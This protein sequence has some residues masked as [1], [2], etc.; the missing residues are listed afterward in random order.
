MAM[1]QT[2]S[3]TGYSLGRWDLSELLSS[4]SDEIIATC[5]QSLGSDV[6]LLEQAR[7]KLS[8]D[9]E[10][11]ELRK[12]VELYESIAEKI[13]VLSA[14]GSL[15]FA[16]DTQD[17]AAL[18]YS[19]R[20]DQVLT[21][22][23]NRLLFFT[24]WWKDLDDEVAKKLL[25]ADDDSKA[26][27]YRHF[28]TD[29]RRTKEYTL[30][31]ASERLINIKD[32][33]GIQAVLTLYSMLTNRLE[34]ELEIDGEAKTLSRSEMSAL[35][36]S[37]DSE[38]R[39]SAYQE[40]HRVYEADAKILGQIYVNRVS[41]WATE[42]R[43]LRGFSSAIGVRNV[44][45]DLPDAAVETLLDV[46][47]ESA[48]IFQR[49]FRLK[50]KWLGVE[51]LR[52]YDL[53]APLA[54]SDRRIPW[55]E[56]V[57]TVLDTFSG[58]DP[59]V[60]DLAR[61][62]FADNHIDS[63]LRKGKKGGAFCATVLPSQTPWVL[64]NYTGKVRDVATLAHELG[65]AVHSLLAEDH[66]ILTQHA[67]L[68]LAETAS[69]FSEQLLTDR[70]L[71]E[72]QDPMVRREL[73]A[74]SMDDIYATVLR[75][76]YFVRFEKDAHRAILEGRSPEALHETYFQGLTEQF[77]DAVEVA[78][79]F[80]Y[81]WVSIPHIYHTPFYC[82]AYSFGQLLVLALYSRYKEEGEA[83]IPGYLRLLAHGGSA[84][85]QEIL[86]EVGVDATDPEFWRGGFKVVEGIVDELETL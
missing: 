51:K 68:P 37:P 80:R 26:A 61:R 14:Y 60:G 78:D 50:A 3:K 75:Q 10:P 18:T 39:A 27:D 79:E 58:F 29:V 69:V 52:R 36:Y 67:S 54:T 43:Q 25:P 13:Y 57:E 48:P 33:N 63:E 1:T 77:G 64:V 47:S 19:N 9:L 8:P 49:Y 17:E 7:P 32:T 86:S 4:P 20:M 24:L 40:L 12:L 70:L 11:A 83:F 66:S 21:S 53:Y 30:D 16:S 5:V 34:F 76:A 45:N 28:L 31:E 41:D 72:E 55:G 85:P 73:L 81:E 71:G 84:R 23:Q 65:H 22:F 42:N 82:Y 59:R 35:F 2:E 62:V 44:A 74:S 56:A 38:V 46:C 15:W 6:Q